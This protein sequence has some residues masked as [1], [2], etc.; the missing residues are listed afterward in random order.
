VAGL[1]RKAL[2]FLL[3]VI[4]VVDLPIIVLSFFADDVLLSADFYSEEFEKV[5]LYGFL[6]DKFRETLFSQV[7]LPGIEEVVTDAWVREQIDANLEGFV[8]YLR[9]EEERYVPTLYMAEIKAGLAEK[10]PELPDSGLPD[11]Y[12]IE[13]GIELP[14]FARAGA[15]GVARA[16][17]A[18]VV[19]A[20]TVGALL[21][22][23]YEDKKKFLPKVGRKV[24][25]SG[26]STLLMV[27]L[28]Y[29][30]VPDIAAS[31][32][33]MIPQDA[34]QVIL[35]DIVLRLGYYGG[36]VFAVGLVMGLTG[37][38]LR[39]VIKGKGPFSGQ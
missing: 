3:T 18:S 20:V 35:R 21:F 37:L 19:L 12:E 7:D 29:W 6:G 14:N 39:K 33:E 38:G 26:L 4:L 24:A 23:V 5:G 9:V 27:G 15:A 22:I 31:L 13:E 8:A 16:K 17:A 11:E 10:Y 1:A 25:G 30:K 36:I 32:P 2:V 28:V 34:F